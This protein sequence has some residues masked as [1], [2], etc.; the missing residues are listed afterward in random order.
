MTDDETARDI[1]TRQILDAIAL[2]VVQLTQ[3]QDLMERIALGM[4]VNPNLLRASR[5]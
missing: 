3:V 4:G 5:K 1:Q 2:V